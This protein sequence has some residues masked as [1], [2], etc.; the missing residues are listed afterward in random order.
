VKD[1]TG[2]PRPVTD[3]PTA[4]EVLWNATDRLRAL[5]EAAPVSIVAFDRDG[6]VT[7]WNLAADRLFGWRASEVIGRPNPLYWTPARGR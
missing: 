1:E 6:R 2:E 3:P 5:E 7:I 4:A